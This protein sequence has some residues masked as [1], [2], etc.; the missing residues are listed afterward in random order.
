M[1]RKSIP[2]ALAGILMASAGASAAGLP[3]DTAD[4]LSRSVHNGQF[5]GVI[6]GLID[7]KDTTTKAFGVASKETGRAP[8]ADTVF[9]IGSISKTFTAT[10]LAEEVNAG[11]MS[12][13]DPV[14]KYLPKG[15]TLAQVGARAITLEDVAT[16]YSGLPRMPA[17]FNPTN[18]A[19][20][21]ADL[22]VEKLWQAV[23]GA[24]PARAPG[25]APEYSNFGF[26]MLGQLI[27]RETGMSYRDLLKTRIFAPLSMTS[28]D[29]V[30]TDALKP[31]AAQGYGADGKPVPHWTIGGFEAAGAINST[32]TDMLAYVRA[33]MAASSDSSA[34]D[35][36]RAMAMAHKPRAD[37]ANGMR[38]GL[39]WLTTPDGAGH[40][41][42]G[43]TGGFR[44]YAG[45][46]DDGER[47][48]VVLSNQGTRSLDEIGFHLLNPGMP[49][50]KAYEQV[51]V[52]ADKLEDYVG[53]YQITPQIVFTV[54]R[55]GDRLEVQLTGQP[56][57]PVFPDKPDHF[58]Y[59]A[60]QAD[61][62]FERTDDGKISGLTL[63]Q[64]GR[65]THADRLGP[66]GKPVVAVKHL[67]LSPQELDA[68]VG[69]YRLSPQSNF[70]IT[71]EGT[72]L[73]A[74]LATQPAIQ[75]YPDK[76]DH[77]FYTVVDAQISFERDASGKVTAL[78]LHQNGRNMQAPRIEPKK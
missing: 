7:G 66:D 57:A 67:D 46:N 38:I 50:P 1:Q 30:L 40:W 47:G 39:A 76:P 60:V 78:T 77:F 43:G 44:S 36:S 16:H 24:M 23:N 12:L 8:D 28:S 51:A 4:Y 56:F 54:K 11:R 55:E 74:K 59:K 26:A 5:V 19:D 72:H 14:Q 69:E 48:V 15:V 63:H 71:R 58:F 42:N 18:P 52:A 45:F 53:T 33:N 3:A 35:L 13:S 73:M 20:P 41:H 22:D 37:F 6:V 70:V 10:L 62:S 21:Y 34:S 68:Y 27:A 29:A 25:V 17:D 49:L 2:L 61:I 75:I 9:E 64:G 32:V 31:R 65:D